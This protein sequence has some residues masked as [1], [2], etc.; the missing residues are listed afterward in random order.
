[1]RSISSSAQVEN[2]S[3][4]GE[5]SCPFYLYDSNPKC[6][7]KIKNSF[8]NVCL[9]FITVS[10]SHECSAGGGVFST[11]ICVYVGGG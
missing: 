3:P 2:S 1:M 8:P 9:K 11:C 10:F 5:V 6:T 4:N 7:F